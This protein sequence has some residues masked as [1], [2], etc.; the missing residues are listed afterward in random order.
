MIIV[1][2][3]I[4]NMRGFESIRVFHDHEPTVPLIAI[5]GYAFSGLKQASPEFLRMA[6][7]RDALPAQAL[8]ADDIAERDRRMPVG[9]RA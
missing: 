9:G 6:L 3:F 7:R 1:D 4:P 8:H 2:V 5:S